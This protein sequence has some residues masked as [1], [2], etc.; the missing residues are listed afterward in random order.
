[1]IMIDRTFIPVTAEVKKITIKISIRDLEFK[2][3]Y[4]DE[5]AIYIF[6][7]KGVLLD[8]TRIFA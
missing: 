8:N 3:H 7:M 4:F 1:M 2:I 6:Y 5:Y